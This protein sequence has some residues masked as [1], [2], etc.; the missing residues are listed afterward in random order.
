[1]VIL[2]YI[3]WPVSTDRRSEVKTRKEIKVLRF[4]KAPNFSGL[5]LDLFRD[6][7]PRP[8]REI[9]GLKSKIWQSK[10]PFSRRKRFLPS[11]PRK[12]S[13]VNALT[14]GVLT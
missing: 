4:H 12:A 10:N 8:V 13:A 6:E 2:A 14:I 1:M 3:T 5:S 11:S 9:E 7:R